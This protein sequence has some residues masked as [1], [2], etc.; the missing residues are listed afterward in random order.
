M[1]TSTISQP[2]ILNHFSH[3]K[4]PRVRPVTYPLQEIILTVV[5]ATICGEE[6]WEAIAEWATDKLSLLRTFLEFEQGIPSPDTFRRVIERINPKEFLSSFVEWTQEFEKR[7]EGQICIDGKVLKR[8]MENGKPINIVSAWCEDNRVILGAVRTAC[9]SNEITAIPELLD[10]LVLSEG[11]TITIDA[12]GCQ[13]E[14]VSKIQSFNANYVIALKRNQQLLWA[15]IDNFFTQAVDSEE[16]APCK[17]TKSFSDKRGRDDSQ[18]VWIS[19]QLDWLPQKKQWKGLNTIIMVRRSWKEKEKHKE[20]KR[21]YISSLSNIDPKDF[22][23]IIRRHWSIE[24][25]FHW[26][27]DVTFREDDSCISGTANE[28][29]RVARMV[30]LKLLKSE[31]SFKKGL[32]A[33]SRKCVRSNDYLRK[34]LLSGNF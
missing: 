24:N 4:D 13:K 31:T 26:H 30:G 17:K 1:S 25:E 32:K 28:N 9:K 19:K 10:S 2:R 6:G 22:S 15:E 12:I 29:L 21:Y 3:C 7:S 33:K 23:Q 5:L 11:D 27:L 18:E 14:I 8:A 20:E 16:Y 34:V